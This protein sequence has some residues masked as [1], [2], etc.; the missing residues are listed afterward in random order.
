MIIKLGWS[1]VEG[2]GEKYCLYLFLHARPHLC[3]FEPDAPGLFYRL[4]SCFPTS[5]RHKLCCCNLKPF[6]AG[7]PFKSQA[8]G[9]LLVTSKGAIKEACTLVFWQT[10]SNGGRENRFEQ[11]DGHLAPRGQILFW[12]ITAQKCQLRRSEMEHF[13]LDR[14]MLRCV[15]LM[16]PT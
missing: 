1:P 14:S 13:K 7:W 15:W 16:G 2:V 8:D 9:R 5:P 4:R 6:V 3:A 11:V 12:R 10:T